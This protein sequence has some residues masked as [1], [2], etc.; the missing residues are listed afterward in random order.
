MESKKLGLKIEESGFSR[1]KL[2]FLI[3][4]SLNFP[5]SLLVIVNFIVN[6]FYLRKMQFE[7]NLEL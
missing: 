1:S 7:Y 5:S 2:H 3:F 6:I 4:V